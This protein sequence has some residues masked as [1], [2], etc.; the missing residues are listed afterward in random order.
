MRE[1][2]RVVDESTCKEYKWEYH[3]R[4][5]SI[6]FLRA[7]FLGSRDPRGFLGRKLRHAPSMRGSNGGGDGRSSRRS[8]GSIGRCGRSKR[9]KIRCLEAGKK[10]GAYETKNVVDDLVVAEG[11]MAALWGRIPKHLP[12]NCHRRQETYLVSNNP[13]SRKNEALEPPATRRGRRRSEK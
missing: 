9:R 12:L 8:R 6:R 10:E 3:Q 13:D 1:T 2:R 5:H 4:I 7:A 11:T